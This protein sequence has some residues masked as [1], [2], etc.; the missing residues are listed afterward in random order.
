MFWLEDNNIIVVVLA[1]VVVV[2]SGEEVSFLVGNT[3][4][5]VENE[6]VFCEFSDPACLASVQ[7]LGFLEVLEV[8]MIHPDFNIFCGTHEVVSPFG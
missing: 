5:M 8:L 1:L 3:R 6:V 7:F 2:S 4:L